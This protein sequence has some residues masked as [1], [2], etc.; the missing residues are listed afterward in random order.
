MTN[1]ALTCVG[2]VCNEIRS[3]AFVRLP[4]AQP[5]VLTQARS[6]CNNGS[7]L[8]VNNRTAVGSNNLGF[9]CRNRHQSG[10]VFEWS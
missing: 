1:E 8:T 7:D 5:Q 3:E 10:S 2:V 6:S 9:D 4:K